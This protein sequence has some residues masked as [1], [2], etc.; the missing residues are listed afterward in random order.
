MKKKLYILAL[1][2]VAF[3]LC[4]MVYDYFLGSHHC[5]PTKRYASIDELEKDLDIEIYPVYDFQEFL[6]ND[7]QVLL[8]DID[9]STLHIYGDK[10][11]QSISYFIEQNISVYNNGIIHYDGRH[12]SSNYESFSSDCR[13]DKIHDGTLYQYHYT[14][15]DIEYYRGVFIK[16]NLSFSLVINNSEL[17]LD[18]ET[19]EN[20]LVEYI[21]LTEDTK[22]N[23]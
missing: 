13:T 8:K 16:D 14:D 6:T 18:T 5:N 17:Q 7:K 19:I 21:Q 4:Y 1:V 23:N 15:S 9:T 2:V 3:V 10:E 22:N 12:N 20:K 11:N